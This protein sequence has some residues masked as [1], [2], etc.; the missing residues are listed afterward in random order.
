S[1]SRGERR[2][3]AL[4]LSTGTSFHSTREEVERDAADHRRGDLRLLASEVQKDFEWGTVG[5]R[6]IGHAQF[7]LKAFEGAKET[8]EAVRNNDPNDLEANLL[9]GTI[10]ERLGDL[11]RSTQP[12][13]RSA[14]D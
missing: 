6:A 4:R 8:W 7:K 9:L 2:A 5:L 1:F 13:I 14:H 10:Y 12:Y 11:T 3:C